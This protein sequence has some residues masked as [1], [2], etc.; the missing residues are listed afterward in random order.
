[1]PVTPWGLNSFP[2]WVRLWEVLQRMSSLPLTHPWSSYWTKSCLPPWPFHLRRHCPPAW[3]C[4]SVVALP[5]NFPSFPWLS[6]LTHFSLSLSLS[7][8]FL[9]ARVYPY[10]V[11]YC[12]CVC[13]SV[14]LQTDQSCEPTCRIRS[15]TMCKSCLNC[16]TFLGLDVC[17]NLVRSVPVDRNAVATA[18]APR[19]TVRVSWFLK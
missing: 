2:S 17:A 15:R 10:T 1:M 4:Q 9:I 14:C 3:Q 18:T 8:S 16:A 5:S 12:V 11:A 13:M 19:E 7:L 6:S